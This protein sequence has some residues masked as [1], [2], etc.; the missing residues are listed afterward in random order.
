[1]DLEN[2]LMQSKARVYAAQMNDFV[3]E[4]DMRAFDSAP[5]GIGT[6]IEVPRQQISTPTTGP[7]APMFFRRTDQGW[8]RIPRP[9]PGIGL[10]LKG[11]AAGAIAMLFLC[12]RLFPL[13]GQNSA[14]LNQLLFGLV[15][16]MC[17]AVGPVLWYMDW[18]KYK[19]MVD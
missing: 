12:L 13:P 4:E 18:V 17:F 7:L 6:K 14:D 11:W 9:K 8:Q 2:A 1:M 16:G 10:L 19:N 15:G 5:Y 3:R